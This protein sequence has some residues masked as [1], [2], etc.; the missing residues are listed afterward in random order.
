MW[1]S[2]RGRGASSHKILCRYM[3][4]VQS[5][6]HL[7]Q[8]SRWRPAP[9]WIF[10]LCKFGYFA[11]LIVRYLCS[12]PNLVQISVIVTEIDVYYAS[13]A[14]RHGPCQVSTVRNCLQVSAWHGPTVLDGAVRSYSISQR[15][16]TP[17]LRAE[18]TAWDA[19]IS[20]I[21]L[22]RSFVLLCCTIALEHFAS[23]CYRLYLSLHS[24]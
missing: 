19:P 24:F 14:W 12:M 8:N 13:L 20:S 2:P 23:D 10:R 3:Y 17:P 18:R 22:R 15:T 5:Y 1:S 11:V 6:W 4:P 9:S 7:F 16:S 21:E